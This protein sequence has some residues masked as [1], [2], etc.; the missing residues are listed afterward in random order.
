MALVLEQA[1]DDLFEGPLA[2]GDFHLA[3][4]RHRVNLLI[5]EPHLLVRAQRVKHQALAAIR[6]TLRSSAGHDA[7]DGQDRHRHARDRERPATPQPQAL[8]SPAPTPRCRPTSGRAP[9]RRATRRFHGDRDHVGSQVSL[10][11]TMAPMDPGVFAEDV[12]DRPAQGLGAV[13]DEQHRLLEIKAAIDDIGQQQPGEGG[14]LRRAF[15][16]HERDPREPS[17][18]QP[19]TTTGRR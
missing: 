11:A 5:A 16:E 7:L 10:L 6:A 19:P 9:R 17:S 8:R 2:V 1:R 14:V 18:P 4:G 15:P 3:R 12:L 13:D